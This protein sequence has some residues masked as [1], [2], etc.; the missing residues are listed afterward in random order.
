MEWAEATGK[1]PEKNQVAYHFS[2]I[3][4]PINSLFQIPHSHT[5]SQVITSN[6]ERECKTLQHCYSLAKIEII[7][8]IGS[9]K[10]ARTLDFISDSR[11]TLK[12]FGGPLWVSPLSLQ[13]EFFSLNS[14]APLQ[15]NQAAMWYQV[16]ALAL[17]P[18]HHLATLTLG[19][20]TV[21]WVLA[22]KQVSILTSWSKPGANN[23]CPD[24][25]TLFTLFFVAEIQNRLTSPIT[26]STT[27]PPIYP[28]HCCTSCLSAT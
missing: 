6:V 16:R 11:L 8:G 21:C 1:A 24:V 13:H 22:G 15:W 23:H 7:L 9:L 25:S 18:D 3:F 10:S 17:Q 19:I 14:G 2:Q 12:I 20:I 26:S 28:S 5:K 27:S 4:W